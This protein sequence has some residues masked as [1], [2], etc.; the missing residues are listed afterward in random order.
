MKPRGPVIVPDGDEYQ[1]DEASAPTPR[2]VYVPMERRGVKWER[3]EEVEGESGW[4]GAG[5]A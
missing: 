3:G 1:L 5:D 2:P 4:R